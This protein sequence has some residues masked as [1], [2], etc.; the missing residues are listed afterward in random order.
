MTPFLLALFA[1]APPALVAEVQQDSETPEQQIDAVLEA[2]AEAMEAWMERMQSATTNDE[3]RT[4]YAENPSQATAN[5]L[6][7]LVGEVDA[8]GDHAFKAH[9]FIVQNMRGGELFEASLKPLTEHHVQRA[10]IKDVVTA[11]DVSSPDSKA[12]ERFVRAVLEKSSDKET[13]GIA[14][15][16]LASG[17][18]YRIDR[19]SPSPEDAKRLEDEALGLYQRGLTEFADVK[20]G[21]GSTFGA[22]AEKD[23]FELENLMPGKTAPDIDG[24]DLG[25]TAFKLSDYR[26]KVVM[27]DFWGDW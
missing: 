22:E 24:E 4:I 2:H 17:L 15:Y 5:Q 20:V 8:A 13:Q 19:Y 6:A 1:A 9:S 23:I 21:R 10:G 26:G 7:E 16:Q 27:L 3:R 25:G 11:V 14:C 12:A 18:K